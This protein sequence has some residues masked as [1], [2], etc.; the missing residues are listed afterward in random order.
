[1]AAPPRDL[2]LAH[3]LSAARQA[4]TAPAPAQAARRDVG[5]RGGSAAAPPLRAGPAWA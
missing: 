1:M 3:S 2:F 5:E 4:G